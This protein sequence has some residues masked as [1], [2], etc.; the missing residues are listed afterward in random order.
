MIAHIV[1][2]EPKENVTPD[3]KRSFGQLLVSLASSIDSIKRAYIGRSV[4]LDPG[5]DRHFGDKT[6]SFAAVL[7]FDDEAG[8]LEYLK[9]PKHE[10]LGRLFWLWCDSTA[11]MEVETRDLKDDLRQNLGDFLV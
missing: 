6:Y 11:I 3:Q 2:F 10:E 7:E 8:L 4:R 5:Y 1:F 9:H